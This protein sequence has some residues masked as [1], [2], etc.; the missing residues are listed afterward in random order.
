MWEK[1]DKNVYEN[2]DSFYFYDF[3]SNW[4]DLGCNLQ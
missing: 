4:F 3:L 1:T 2:A